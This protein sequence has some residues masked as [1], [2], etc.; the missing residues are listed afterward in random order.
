[1]IRIL[2]RIFRAILLA[3]A[4]GGILF[5]VHD[6]ATASM[7]VTWHMVAAPFTFI[8][9]P[10][11]VLI[12]APWIAILWVLPFY[13][14][15]SLLGKPDI[16]ESAR[17]KMIRTII[18]RF[19]IALVI[20]YLTAGLLLL[21]V[22]KLAPTDGITSFLVFSIAVILTEPLIQLMKHPLQS[23]PGGLLLVGLWYAILAVR[24]KLPCDSSLRA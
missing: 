7:E 5:V 13:F 4:V 21:I 8:A 18:R 20:A 9:A 12:T 24:A 3:Y 19:L 6:I 22:F 10:L 2:F 14:L 23:L 16:A 17:M 1:M 15:V 11:E